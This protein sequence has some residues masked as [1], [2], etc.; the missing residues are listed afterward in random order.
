[1]NK[2]SAYEK[3]IRAARNGD[4]A[5]MNELIA[6]LAS[7][8]ES[9]AGAYAGRS[10]LTRSDLIQ[11]GMIG[12]LSAIYGYSFDNGAEFITYARACVTNRVITAVRNQLRDK[13]TPL[14]SYIQLDSISVS[15]LQSDPQFVVEMQEKA[16]ELNSKIE[17]E[18]TELERNVLRLHIGGHNYSYI[19]KE[20]SVSVKSVDNALQ[21]ARK[22]LRGNDTR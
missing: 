1:M 6:A 4:K 14:N 19:A 12:L 5:A 9:I 21:R 16:N 17:N 10:P 13:H 3:N 11:E 8:V 7:L 2:L 15:D 18:L 20:L 22:K